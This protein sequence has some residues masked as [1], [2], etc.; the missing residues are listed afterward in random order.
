MDEDLWTEARAHLHALLDE[1]FDGKADAAW[2]E[3]MGMPAPPLAWSVRFLEGA[4]RGQLGRP[5]PDEEAAARAM[6]A[7]VLASR[8]ALRDAAVNVV[9]AINRDRAEHP[10]QE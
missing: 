6:L 8:D 2:F 9:D 4:I 10:P 1:V 7:K 5:F 3:R